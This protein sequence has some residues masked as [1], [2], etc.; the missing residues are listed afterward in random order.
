M[1]GIRHRIL[2]F[3]PRNVVRAYLPTRSP[4]VD[5]LQHC[6]GIKA[7]PNKITAQAVYIRRSHDATIHKTAV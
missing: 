3:Y 5:L 2:S 6:K 1:R 4:L 7:S